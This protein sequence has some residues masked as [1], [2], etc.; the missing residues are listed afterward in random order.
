MQ[1]SGSTNDK[2]AICHSDPFDCAQGKLWEE[3]HLTILAEI[4]PCSQNDV[5]GATF[6]CCQFTLV[7]ELAVSELVESVEILFDAIF[8]VSQ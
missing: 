2:L 6:F 5:G 8:G 7:I 1:S 4:L 3:S